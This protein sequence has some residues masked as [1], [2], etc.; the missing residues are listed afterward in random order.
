MVVRDWCILNHAHCFWSKALLALQEEKTV[1]S[2]V[3]CGSQWLL[4]CRHPCFRNL[5]STVPIDVV[6]VK[7]YVNSVVNFTRVP[8]LLACSERNL[9]ICWSF[10]S[11]KPYISL[12]CTLICSCM[13]FPVFHYFVIF[14]SCHISPHSFFF[15][16][17]S[18]ETCHKKKDFMKQFNFQVSCFEP[19]SRNVFPISILSFLSY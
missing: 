2:A 6:R 19:K 3:H 12:S 7:S 17:F 14:V 15:Q 1:P 16:L 9:K 5:N 10:S 13:H 18:N 8:V 4:C 11:W